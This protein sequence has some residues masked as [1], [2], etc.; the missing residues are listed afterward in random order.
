MNSWTYPIL[1]RIKDL[2]KQGYMDREI[3]TLLAHEFHIE[4][5]AKNINSARHSHG[6]GVPKRRRPMPMG[7]W[8][9]ARAYTKTKEYRLQIKINRLVSSLGDKDKIETLL[10]KGDRNENTADRG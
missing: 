1:V 9:G 3:A 10:A 6:I 4:C 7:G 2:H 5:T 8:A